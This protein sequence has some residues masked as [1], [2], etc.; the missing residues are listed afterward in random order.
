M[1][2]KSDVSYPCSLLILLMSARLWSDEHHGALLPVSSQAPAD[3]VCELIPARLLSRIANP[4][5]GPWSYAQRAF[6]G[7]TTLCASAPAK[8][9]FQVHRIQLSAAGP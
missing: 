8:R 2:T 4:S 1:R 6:R 5:I 7:Q 3:R 9:K